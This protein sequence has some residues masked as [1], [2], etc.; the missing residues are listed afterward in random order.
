M[1]FP[2]INIRCQTS[3]ILGTFHNLS[4][5][6]LLSVSSQCDKINFLK[7]VRT[8]KEKGRV[9]RDVQAMKSSVRNLGRA[10]SSTSGN[11]TRLKHAHIRNFIRAGKTPQHVKDLGRYSKLSKSYNSSSS[12]CMNQYGISAGRVST[13]SR[14][15]QALTVEP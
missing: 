13:F 1:R 6:S 4:Y 2:K 11:S 14:R 10:P 3:S 9:P 12:S 7:L 5:K 8:S 15:S